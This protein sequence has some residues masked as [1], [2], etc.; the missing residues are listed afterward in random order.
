[1]PDVPTANLTVPKVEKG[2]IG[3]DEVTFGNLLRLWA[4]S[5][6]TKVDPVSGGV[7]SDGI[8]YRPAGGDRFRNTVW[9]SKDKTVSLRAAR[10]EVVAF[11][12]ILERLGNSKLSDVS[13]SVSDL[14][15][16]RKRRSA[17]PPIS[18]HSGCGTSMWSRA[19]WN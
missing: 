2:P 8:N 3:A 10:G 15:W 6:L 9:S 5:D 1:M 14:C 11:Q 16:G 17:L 4:V 18:K 19:P 7:L 13:I 12:L